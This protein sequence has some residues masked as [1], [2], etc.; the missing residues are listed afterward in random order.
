MDWPNLRDVDAFEAIFDIARSTPPEAMRTAL[1]L[2][3]NDGSSIEAPDTPRV[4]SDTEPMP[5][6]AREPSQSFS[7]RGKEQHPQPTQRL[8]TLAEEPKVTADNGDS[9][10]QAEMRPADALFAAARDAIQHLLKSPMKEAEV[11]DALDVSTT[12]SKAWLQRLVKE[13]VM[14]KQKKPAGYIVK[15]AHLFE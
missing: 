11:A 5:H 14:E 4:M 13:G 3:R 6:V 9:L 12:Q 15:Q 1:S 7:S 10:T 2:A 8:P